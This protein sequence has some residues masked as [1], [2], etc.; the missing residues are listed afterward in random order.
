MIITRSCSTFASP[1]ALRHTLRHLKGKRNYSSALFLVV[2]AAIVA[3]CA[4]GCGAGGDGES[5]SPAVE[6]DR[7]LLDGLSLQGVRSGSYDALFFLDNETQGEAVQWGAEGPFIRHG[8]SL[9][10]NARLESTASG[11]LTLGT[12]LDLGDRT[13]LGFGGKSYRLPASTSGQASQASSD[14]QRSLE[15]IEFD[16]LVKN[17]STKPEPVGETTL[18]GDLRLDA[19]LAA[20]NDLTAP[21]ACGFLLKEAGVSPQALAALEAEV[22]RTFKESKA[23]FTFDKDHVLTAFSL[24]IW[25]ESPPPKPEEVDGTLTVSLSRV[26]E[27]DELAAPPSAKALDAQSQAANAAQRSRVEGWIGLVNAVFASLAGS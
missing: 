22:E 21:S 17:L 19:L 14:C 3:T 11:P 26:N 7:Q 2:L 20:L 8:G 27:V 13:I 6:R 9:E 18:E 23:T 24:G 4:V 1:S 5:G 10:T 12:L 15:G 16:T 25:V